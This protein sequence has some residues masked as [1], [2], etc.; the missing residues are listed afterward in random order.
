MSETGERECLTYGVSVLASQAGFCL[1]TAR[2]PS[3][4]SASLSVS[5]LAS[6]ALARGSVVDTLRVVAFLIS[7]LDAQPKACAFRHGSQTDDMR[8]AVLSSVRAA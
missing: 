7:S 3:S 4:K 6:I 5:A 1:R 8:Y 2:D